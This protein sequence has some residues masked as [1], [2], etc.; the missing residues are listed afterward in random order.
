VDGEKD[1]TE[2]GGRA[3]G[4]TSDGS[5]ASPKM[6][7][8]LVEPRARGSI[9]ERGD[10]DGLHPSTPGDVAAVED[11]V[12]RTNP[13]GGLGRSLRLRPSPAE[14]RERIKAL[15][16]GQLA[17]LLAAAEAKAPKLYPLFFVVSRT[18]SASVQ[19]RPKR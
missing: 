15:D 2:M 5:N 10:A 7:V 11:Y 6:L 12:I 19:K 13:A 1:A 14:R 17:R 4:Y 18:V 3:I 9:R 16:R 8:M